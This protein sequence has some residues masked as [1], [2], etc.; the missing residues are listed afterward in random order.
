MKQLTTNSQKNMEATGEMMTSL[1]PEDF[2]VSLSPSQEKE[3][4]RQMTA[5]S[6]RKCLELY[7]IFSR[8]GQSLKTLLDCL[9]NSEAWYS[10][11]CAL[12]WR[13]QGT[14]FNRLLFRLAASERPTS[15][16]AFSLL[17]TAQTQGLKVCNGEGKTAFVDLRLLP[18]P[19]SMMPGDT[20]MNKLN[21]RMER[22][23]DRGMSPVTDGLSIMAVKGLLPTPMVRDYKGKNP[24]DNQNDLN[25]VFLPTPQAAD[26]FKTTK[27]NHQDNLNKTFRTGGTSQ[28][29][30]LFVTE[31]M[32]FPSDWLTS[33]FQSG[34]GKA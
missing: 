3:W 8:H 28:L 20:D 21:A 19:T 14:K 2:P 5:T 4:A 7:W 12:T 22:L 13:P 29:N 32:G 33:P 16:T 30:P 27:A 17:P 9:L 26:G 31:M 34:D 6:G 25:K 23:K 18:T 24:Y 10:K 11:A 15:G 1:F